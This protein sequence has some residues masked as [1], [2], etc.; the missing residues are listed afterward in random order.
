MKRGLSVVLAVFNEEENL[1]RCL[2]AVKGIADEIVIVDGGSTDKTIAIA[3]KYGVRVIETDNPPI[4]HINKQKALGAAKYEWILQLDADEVVSEELTREIS[5]VIRMSEG[6]LKKREWEEGKRRLFE[7]HQKLIEERDGK[8][9][10]QKGEIAAFF[11]ARR[12]LFLGTWMRYGGTYPDGVIRLV[13]KGKAK[14]PCKSVHEQ[15]E[16]VGRVDWLANDLLHWDSPTFS[17]YLKRANAY[18]DLTAAELAREKASLGPFNWL[19]HLVFKP[20]FTF[21]KLYFRHKG[22]KDGF[23]GFVWALFSGLHF[24]IAFFK[25]WNREC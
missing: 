6:E 23:A 1:G 19:N 22:F 10:K 7:R 15:I 13:A 24:P 9:G 12:N 8:V 21:M 18:T 2:S 3:Q 20:I 4:F 14:F 17:K 16:V 5:E 25:Y 11:I